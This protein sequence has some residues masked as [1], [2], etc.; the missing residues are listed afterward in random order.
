VE[1]NPHNYYSNL[2]S[3]AH[4]ATYINFIEDLLD[5]YSIEYI[6]Y[7]SLWSMEE[8][9]DD[10]HRTDYISFSSKIEGNEINGRPLSYH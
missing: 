6:E 2:P 9:E 4:F 5:Y 1:A 7:I 10:F 3:L 8:E